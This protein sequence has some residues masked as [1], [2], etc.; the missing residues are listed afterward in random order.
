MTSAAT[1]LLDAASAIAD[2]LS[3]PDRVRWP[4]TNRASPASLAG[5]A[6]GVALLHVHRAR[7]GHGDE[8]T[9]HRWLA[10]AT[11]DPIS[12]GPNAN[13]FN[14]APAICFVLRAAADGTSAYSRPLQAVEDHTLSIAASRLDAAWARIESGAALTMREFDLVHGITG[15]TAH[16]LGTQPEHPVTKR[17]LSYLV[18]L[19][20]RPQRSRPPWWLASGLNG[21]PHPDYP[22]GH[23]NLGVAHGI[24]AVIAVLA[25]AVRDGYA[26]AETTEAL[27]RLCAWTDQWRQHDDA[28]TWWP[29]Y[30]TP[31]QHDCGT[32]RHALRKPRPSW[33]YG[34][35]GTARA[36]QLAGIALRDDTRQAHAKRSILDAINDP[37]LHGKLPEVG[38][39]H[40][41]AG[42]L[43]AAHRMA[44]DSGCPDVRAAAKKL[45]A[46]LA[47]QLVEEPITDPD[48]MDGAAGAAL[49]LHSA[50]TP[51]TTTGPRWDRFL[52]LA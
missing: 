49:A 29:G 22:D 8:N 38:L 4:D 7:T 2:A 47:A 10:A 15:L 39:C 52:L 25:L 21:E 37:Y 3:D 19:T 36:Q 50:A 28:G 27:Q 35:A 26:M 30:L 34:V 48:L 43:T 14:G 18:N 41:K 9:A 1:R 24:S 5:G 23:G 13:L 33:C 45:A 46:H 32:R 44:Q 11:R 51:D 6:V 31:Q 20:E 16:L 42:L 12:A 17:A 40:G